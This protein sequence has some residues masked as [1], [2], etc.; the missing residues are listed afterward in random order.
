MGTDLG[1]L[2]EI[3]NEVNR[4]L[5]GTDISKCIHLIDMPFPKDSDPG[6]DQDCETFCANVTSLS[7]KRT[8]A[9]ESAHHYHPA[10]YLA[11]KFYEKIGGVNPEPTPTCKDRFDAVDISDKNADLASAVGTLALILVAFSIISSDE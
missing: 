10:A 2:Q 8:E 9:L 5:N 11:L 6:Y 1:K 7:T 4:G 3:K